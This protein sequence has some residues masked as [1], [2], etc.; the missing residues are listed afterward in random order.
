M[1]NGK[2]KADVR[3]GKHGRA[4]V[5]G[6]KGTATRT[7]GLLGGIFSY[8]I[9]EGYRSDNPVR[10]IRR[11]PGCKAERF[12]SSAE[13]KALGDVLSTAEKAWNAYQMG[14]AT[15]H[16]DGGTGPRPK[17]PNDA[18][19][20]TVLTAIRLLLFTGCRKSEILTLKWEHI[21]FERSCLRLPDSKTGSKIVL[22]GAPALLLLSGLTRTEGNPYVRQI[23]RAPRG[24]AKGVGAAPRGSQ[25]EG[26]SA[27]RLAP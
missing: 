27:A 2:T 24:P 9:A 6:G 18:V 14:L 4:I 10:G 23:G 19:M 12:L 17:A 5:E 13:L 7:V 22:L 20:P 11:Y 21:D 1:A 8:A 3:T 25:A 26:R 15:W 16:A